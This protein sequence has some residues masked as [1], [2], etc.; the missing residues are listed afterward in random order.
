VRLSALVDDLLSLAELERPG[1]ELRR[2]RFDLRELVESQAR[3]QEPRAQG[4]GLGLVVESG[5]PVPVVADR[6]RILQVVDNLLDNALKYT[7]RG[8]VTLRIGERD[9]RA[10]CEVEDTG[11]G[12]PTD[13]LPRIFER[14]YRVDKARSRQKGGTGLGLSI[15]KHILS[16]H[17]GEISARSEA[18]EG[19]VFR[20]EIP[21][22]G[23]SES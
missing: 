4:A 22:S 10:W 9:G 15:V 13:D 11:S 3:V 16:L 17:G 5:P 20:F 19:S 6:A 8:Q 7:E 12:I 1:A 18:G 21:V 2:E 14:F 23:I